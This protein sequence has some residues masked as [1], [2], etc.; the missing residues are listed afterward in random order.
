MVTQIATRMVTV[1]LILLM[2]SV[3]LAEKKAS[4][5]GP[6]RE[7]MAWCHSRPRHFTARRRRRVGNRCKA[8]P[9]R[10]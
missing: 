5:P 2:T 3:A 4:V 1:T 8:R 6:F 7:K 10:R 9:A